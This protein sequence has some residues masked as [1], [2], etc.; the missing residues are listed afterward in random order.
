MNKTTP[1]PFET[2]ECVYKDKKVI[3]SRDNLFIAFCLARGCTINEVKIEGKDI[4][5]IL[6]GSNLNELRR[7]YDEVCGL[8]NLADFGYYFIDIF[9]A[10]FQMNHR[11]GDNEEK[12][13]FV[14]SYLQG[15]KYE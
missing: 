13:L 1:I 11:T 15:V 3:I 9:E 14:Q 7:R 12:K 6:S 5:L 2:K 8:F 10:I 4:E